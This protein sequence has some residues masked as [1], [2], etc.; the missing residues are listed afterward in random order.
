MWVLLLSPSVRVYCRKCQ[1][2]AYYYPVHEITN[3]FSLGKR[4]CK[5][6]IVLLQKIAIVEYWLKVHIQMK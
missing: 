1:N 5:K 6:N 3:E 4:N 2:V